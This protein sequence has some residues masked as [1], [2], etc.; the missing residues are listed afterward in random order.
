M[1]RRHN[2]SEGLLGTWPL[3]TQLS[4]LY[5]NIQYCLLIKKLMSM[6]KT[7]STCR[8]YHWPFRRRTGIRRSFLSSDVFENFE[9][10]TFS[11]CIL[12]IAKHL[13]HSETD[14]YY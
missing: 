8:R 4:T 14:L 12:S 10:G 11:R 2:A 6:Y 9:R 1:P 3:A 7:K 13:R 5:S